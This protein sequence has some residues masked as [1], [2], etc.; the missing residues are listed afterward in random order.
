MSKNTRICLLTVMKPYK[1]AEVFDH[2]TKFVSISYS[3]LR[4]TYLQMFFYEFVHTTN[5][6]IHT[7]ELHIG[8]VVLHFFFYSLWVEVIILHFISEIFVGNLSILHI[9]IIT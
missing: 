1:N 8:Y 6:H 2:K 9:I 5:L 7:W 3:S 4:Y